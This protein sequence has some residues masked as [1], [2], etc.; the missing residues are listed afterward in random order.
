MRR[1]SC[2]S[3]STRRDHPRRSGRQHIDL[4]SETTREGVYPLRACN[5]QLERGRRHDVGDAD[6]KYGLFLLTARS[7]SRAT[8][9]E[10]L[11]AS[12]RT[13]TKQ[14]GFLDAPDNLVAVGTPGPHDP[15]FQAPLLERRGDRL[16][17]LYVRLAWRMKTKTLA[18]RIWIGGTMAGLAGLSTCQQIPSIPTPRRGSFRLC[19]SRGT[20]RRSA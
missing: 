19:S 13:R 17:L 15:A 14:R 10:S 20:T 2:P 11:L 1:R 16:G 18:L 5:E 7:T 8:K 3:A 6:G 12:E 4:G 9:A